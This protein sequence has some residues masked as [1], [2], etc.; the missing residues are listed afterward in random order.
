MKKIIVYCEANLSE[1]KLLD[2]SYELI[3]KAYELTLKAKES[4]NEDYIVEAVTLCH[5]IKDES[6]KKAFMAGASRFVHVKDATFCNFSQTIFAQCFVEYYN[7]SQ[8]DIII[9]PA[10]QK[11]RI[12]AP[13]ITTILDT[14]LV[15]D[16]TGLDFI[17]RE[18]KLKFAPTRPTFG[19]ELMATIISK[20]NPQCA[21]VRPKTF[22]ATFDKNIDGELNEFIPNY[23][24]EPRMKL[25]RSVVDNSSKSDNFD[26][27]KII[28][29]AGYGLVDKKD[30]KYFTRLERLAEIFGAKVGATRKV[31]DMGL[32]PISSQIGQTGVT[33]TPEVYVSFGVSGAIQHIMGMKNSKTVIAIN[34]DENAEIFKYSDYRIVADAKKIIDEMLEQLD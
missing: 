32:M 7:N 1:K 11:G 12:L 23:Y 14:G 30:K 22:T 28:F 8:G 20:K 10:T 2:V 6:V 17:I 18:N 19:S 24:Q 13:R 5:E 26:N 15:A 21:T 9:F 29:V 4:I 33:I 16:C 31:V 3:S 25:L 34:T 27:Y